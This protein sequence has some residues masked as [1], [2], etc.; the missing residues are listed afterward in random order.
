MRAKRARKVGV[1]RHSCI[2]GMATTA[3]RS[4]HPFKMKA[5]SIGFAVSKLVVPKVGLEPTK[6][7]KTKAAWPCEVDAEETGA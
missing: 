4:S 5:E 6:N 3:H 1:H 2:R 7:L